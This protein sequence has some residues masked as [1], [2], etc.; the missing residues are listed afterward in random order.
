V[1]TCP[2]I[3]ANGVRGRRLCQHNPTTQPASD[4][5]RRTRRRPAV[6]LVPWCV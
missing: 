3:P 5:Q 6:H 1:P 2:T 4:R